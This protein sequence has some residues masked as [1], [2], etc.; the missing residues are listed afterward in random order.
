MTKDQILREIHQTRDAMGKDYT[1]VRR[2]LD[3]RTKFGRAV[4]S[5]P[6]TWLGAAA[7]L[8]W[9]LAGPKTKTRTVT[10]FVA[11]QE[12]KPLPRTEKK[13]GSRFGLIGVGLGVGKLFWPMARP[14]VM[15]FAQKKLAEATAKFSGGTH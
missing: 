10:K 5:H 3:V 14:F 8:G 1:A 15:N 4:G 11:K 12:G 9:L 6:A 7:A 13:K 2:E